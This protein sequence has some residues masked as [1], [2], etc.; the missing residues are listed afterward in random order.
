MRKKHAPTTISAPIARALAPANAR[1][2]SIPT[3][4][5]IARAL[6]SIGCVLVGGVVA[7]S[8]HESPTRDTPSTNASASTSSSPSSTT[9]ASASTSASLDFA[10]GVDP[11]SP[12]GSAVP[13]TSASTVAA[14]AS[15][16]ASVHVF[17]HISPGIGTIGAGI[18][19]PGMAGGMAPMNPID[20]TKAATP[21]VVEAGLSVSGSESPDAVHKVVRARIGSIRACYQKGLAS[22]PTLHGVVSTT[23]SIQADGKVGKASESSSLGNAQV[24]SCIQRVFMTMTFPT[25]DGDTTVVYPFSFTTAGD[26]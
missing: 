9:V 2:G 23:F 8:K 22:D 12:L 1:R 15:C 26:A 4:A 20:A 16:S 24:E 10:N 6:A 7:C 17:P 5:S 25:A 14:V 18:K 21:K 19:T 11:N 13:S 3:A